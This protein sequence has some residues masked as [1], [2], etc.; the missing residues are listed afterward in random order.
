[1]SDNILCFEIKHF[2][3]IKTTNPEFT[4]I[5]FFKEF[6]LIILHYI[7]LLLFTKFF[8]LMIDLLGNKKYIIYAG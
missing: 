8:R 5:V 6:V 2:I 7:C 1:M 3:L 4:F